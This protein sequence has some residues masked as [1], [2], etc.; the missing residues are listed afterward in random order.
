MFTLEKYWKS[1]VNYLVFKA[2]KDNWKL[3]AINLTTNLFESFSEG[4]TFGVIYLAVTLIS[5]DKALDTSH[6]GIIR[7][8]PSLATALAELPRDRAFLLML[9]LAVGLQAVM[10][11]SKYLNM[12]TAGYFAARLRATITGFIHEQILSMTYACASLYK[13]GDLVNYANS[14]DQ[15]VR[16]QVEQINIFCVNLFLTLAYLI[17]L[18]YISPWLFLASCILAGV[19]LI[20]Q[21]IILPKLTKSAYAAE[22]NS[23]SVSEQITENIQGL[24]LLH[25]FSLLNEANRQVNEKLFKLES[26]LKRQTRIY[27]IAPIVTSLLPVVAIAVIAAFSIALISSSSGLVLPGLITFVLALQRF[28][29]RLGMF[30]SITN[31]LAE[32]SGRLRRLNNILRKDDKQFIKA[33]GL[34]F[35]N[36]KH[37]ISF[38]NVTFA[39][40]ENFTPVLSNIC[41]EMKARTV[42]ALVGHSGSGKSTLADL[43]IGLYEPTS[44]DILVDGLSTGD[45]DLSSWR[46]HIGVVSQD[47]F[48]FNASIRDNLCIGLSQVD[49]LDMTAAA[50]AANAHSFITALPEGY[51]TVVGERGF[52]LSGGQRQRLALARAI[53]RKPQILILD[54][55]TSALDSESELHIKEALEEIKQECTILVVAHRLSTI[56]TADKIVVLDQG[57]IAESGTHKELL[58]RQGLYANYWSLQSQISKIVN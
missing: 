39:Y 35:K 34:E 56:S 23:V 33:D 25:S 15:A 22:E 47:S 28:S 40:Q 30:S 27:N 1:P 4:A 9:A 10:S 46:K 58:K 43:V 17:V 13:V 37:G 20:V 14:A 16:I 11:A 38:K 24:R 50:T 42:T 8:V 3:L 5:S 12:V 26:I 48:L 49:E 6:L 32:N 55:A 57:K 2:A 54:E 52:R 31:I 36:L 7:W 29:T 18:V 21:K 45:L 51:D 53:L 41:L 19:L 44:G